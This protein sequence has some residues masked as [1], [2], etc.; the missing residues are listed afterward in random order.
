[1]KRKITF[2]LKLPLVNLHLKRH[3]GYMFFKKN[4]SRSFVLLG[5]LQFQKIFTWYIGS[6]SE[7]ISGNIFICSINEKNNIKTILQFYFSISCWTMAQNHLYHLSFFVFKQLPLCRAQ[8]Y[9]NEDLLLF[10]KHLRHSCE[11]GDS[12]S[13]VSS[14]N[15]SPSFCCLFSQIR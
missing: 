9:R 1:M 7:N 8:R 14:A 12:V 6:C 4:L 2:F 10:L 5:L 11:T 15:K 3:C 13:V